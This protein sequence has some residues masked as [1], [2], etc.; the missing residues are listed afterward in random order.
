MNSK[1]IITGQV[2]AMAKKMYKEEEVIYVQFLNKNDNGGVEIQQI[3]L[4]DK[5]D[6]LSI[7][8]GLTVKIPVKVSSFENKLFFTQSEPMLK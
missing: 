8:E 4:T 6:T 1:I 2:F 3:K 5:N 7:K